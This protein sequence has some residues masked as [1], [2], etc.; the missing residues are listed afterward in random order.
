MLY[1]K[2]RFWV[3]RPGISSEPQLWP[4][5]AATAMPN[6]Q[7]CAR[8]G[9]K[10]VFQ[11]SQDATNPVVPQQELQGTFLKVLKSDVFR[12]MQTSVQ[13]ILYIFF[14]LVSTRPQKRFVYKCI[15]KFYSFIQ[16]FIKR[17][18]DWFSKDEEF[19]H[20]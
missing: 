8:P 3:F 10:P 12:E 14:P 4:T 7:P 19:I 15:R 16:K 5:A 9:I 18:T 2:G 11:H 13:I 6:P 17:H 20:F 1:N